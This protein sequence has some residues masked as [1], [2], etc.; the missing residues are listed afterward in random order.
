MTSDI[1]RA[2]RWFIADPDIVLDLTTGRHGAAVVVIDPAGR[3]L[4]QQRDDDTPPEGY[5]RWAIPGGG[6]EA[7]ETPRQTALREIEE[8]TAIRLLT[9]TYFGSVQ[10]QR[11]NERPDSPDLTIHMFFAR[12]DWPESVIVVGEGLAFCYWSAEE[13]RTLP[14]N[15]NGRHWLEH[16]LASDAFH[17][18]AVAE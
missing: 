9:V 8:E 14:M 18:P 2:N 13:S 6:S 16:L 11:H 12:E 15:P 17:N 10:V 4:L 1:E 3:V 7:G 5:G